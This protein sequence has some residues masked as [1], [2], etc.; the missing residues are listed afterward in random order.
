MVILSADKKDY[1]IKSEIVLPFYD[2]SFSGLGNGDNL[3]M[4]DDVSIELVWRHF[5]WAFEDGLV[6]I[7][8]GVSCGAEHFGVSIRAFAF[9]H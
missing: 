6:V 1:T 7:G 4:L 9:L 5:T 3:S 2:F 8:H